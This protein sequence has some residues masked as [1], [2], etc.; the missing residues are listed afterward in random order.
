MTR[1]FPQ[2]WQR[3]GVRDAESV[4]GLVDAPVSVVSKALAFRV[5]D[6]AP[7]SMPVPLWHGLAGAALLAEHTGH[8]VGLITTGHTHHPTA[9]LL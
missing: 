2:A 4:S 5:L 7:E 9:C 3:D 6:P 8:I 1:G